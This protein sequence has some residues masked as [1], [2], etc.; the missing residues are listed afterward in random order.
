MKSWLLAL[1]SV[2]LVSCVD[3]EHPTGATEANNLTL[4]IEKRDQHPFLADHSRVL[5]AQFQGRKIDEV[6]IYPDPGTGVPLHYVS[7]PEKITAVDGNGVWYQITK[8]GIEK[9]GWEWMKP[10]PK[11]K[12]WRIA[13]N[14]DGDYQTTDAESMDLGDIYIY[15]DPPD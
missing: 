2:A 14:P 12:V 9:I 6:E 10:L 13:R 8:S 4:A 11:G 3:R 7:T 1:I 5:V 15:K